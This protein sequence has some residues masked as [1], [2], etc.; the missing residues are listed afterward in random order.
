MYC[1]RHI[2]NSLKW[3]D[4]HSHPLQDIETTLPGLEAIRSTI[5][6]LARSARDLDLLFRTIID[7]SPW[8]LDPVC[9][10]IAYKPVVLSRKISFAWSMGDSVLSPSPPV[11]RAMKRVRRALENLGHEVV[12]W[13]YPEPRELETL[14]DEL[15]HIAGDRGAGGW[16]V[17]PV[18]SLSLL[19]P[20]YT[21]AEE[22]AR[23]NEPW[24]ESIREVV[25][26][27]AASPRISSWYALMIRQTQ[28]RTRIHLILL[29]KTGQCSIGVNSIKSVTSESGKTLPILPQ[30]V[31]LSTH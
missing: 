9:L 6:P 26:P 13:T 11:A 10:P 20:P 12:E 21:V 28:S 22:L 27:D 16:S 1:L 15:V 17:L 25:C 2:L 31:G 23:G 24:I 4:N 7:A 30:R 19:T 14:F 8:K 5:G 29:P 3:I 18:L